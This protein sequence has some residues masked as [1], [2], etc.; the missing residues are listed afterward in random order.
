VREVLYREAYR[1]VLVYNRTRKRNRWGQRQQ[2][3]RPATDWIRVPAEDLRIVSEALWNA[4]HGQLTERRENYRIAKQRHEQ[5]PDARGPREATKLPLERIRALWVLRRL[6]AGD[7]SGIHDGTPV[8]VRLRPVRRPRRDRLRKQAPRAAGPGRRGGQ[9]AACD[10]GPRPT[11]VEAALEMA[12]AMLTPKNGDQDNRSV[13]SLRRQL[14][15]VEQTLANLV[16]TAAKGGAV[17]AVLEA[18]NRA[19]EERRRLERELVEMTVPVCRRSFDVGSL[20]RTLRGYLK[21]WHD[22]I[23]D[24]VAEARGLLTVV[25]RER[26]TFTPKLGANGDPVCEL[27]I[28]IVFDRLLVSVVPGLEAGF[29]RVG[30]ASPTGTALLGLAAKPPK[31]PWM[32]PLPA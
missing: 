22:M 14:R 15:D 29:A 32:L 7:F 30:L 28:P 20:R 18:L 1:G 24:N 19:D 11:V 4:A 31:L 27:K 13:I 12:I 8:P 17:P 3:V 21:D 5:L 2:H 9:G 25:L 16:E 23:R 26:I 6:R 10:R